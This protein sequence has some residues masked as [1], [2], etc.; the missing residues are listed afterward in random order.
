VSVGAYKLRETNRMVEE[1]MLLANSAVAER[2]YA[3]YPSCAVLRLGKGGGGGCDVGIILLFDC[4]REAAQVAVCARSVQIQILT[5][6][7]APSVA[8]PDPV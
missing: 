1:M 4:F 8:Q 6:R 3:H 2:I 7:K 5:R